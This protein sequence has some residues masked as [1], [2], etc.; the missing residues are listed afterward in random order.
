MKINMREWMSSIIDS[1]EKFALP[2]MTHSGIELIGKSV[3]DAVTNGRVHY[4]AVMALADKY[5]SIA[6]SVIMDLTVEAEAFGAEIH[7]S[8]GEV[9]SVM[10]RLVSDRESIEALE[11]P[12]LDMYRLPEYLLANEL[13]VKASTKPVISGC[14]GPYSLAGRLYDMSEIMMGIYIEPETMKILLDKCTQFITSYCRELKR[15]GINGVLMAEPAA[16]LLSNDACKE[17]SSEFVKRIVDELQDDEFVVILHNCGNTGQCTEA[18][19]Y[20]GAMGY[21]FGNS[22]N[23]VDALN[24]IPEDALVLGNVD[25]VSIFKMSS[26]EVVYDV[27]MNLLKN[28]KEYPNFVLSSGCDTPPEL[29]FANIDSFYRALSDFNKL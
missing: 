16:G 4:A 5:P 17:F 23:M 24:G 21:H 28:T 11:V 18:M 7:F 25:P 9:P 1:S 22:I 10:G 3:N 20:T 13:I 15:L 8:E 6:S 2:I 14:I 27:A 26:P 12:T 19:A 29:P